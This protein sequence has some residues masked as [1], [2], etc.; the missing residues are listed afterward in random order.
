MKVRFLGTGTSQ[1]IPV[2]RCT[3]TVCTSCDER[4]KRLRCS[5][6]VS[7]S[8]TDI[9]IDVGPDLRRQMLL[10]G[11]E[12]LDG[13]FLTHEHND[14][15]AGLDDIR[16]YNFIQKSPLKVYALPRVAKN[17]KH[18]FG[19]VFQ[20]D[21]YPGAPSVELREMR[22][23]SHLN[24]G[25]IRVTAISVLHGKLPILGYRIGSM[26][27]L[28]DVKTIPE[29]S[30]LQL[31]GLKVLI[32]SALRK[33]PHHSHLT[34]SEALHYIKRLKPENAF[35]IHLSHEMGTYEEV[36]EELPK[37]VYLAWD[38]LEIIID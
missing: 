36:Q 23:Y 28:T 24:L 18:R 5:L 26:A 21:K 32:I 8:T 31:Q 22:P 9:L 11:P 38:G 14:H 35:L 1:G 20:K 7:S 33:E 12:K 19:Y 27:Y 16:P 34:L 37:G 2:I 17:L 3:C 25:D 13:I 29:E 10:W 30:L 6:L 4:D 15:T